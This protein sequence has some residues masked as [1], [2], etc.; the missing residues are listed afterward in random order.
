MIFGMQLAEYVKN[1]SRYVRAGIFYV[2]SESIFNRELI[3]QQNSAVTVQA[4][5]Q[6]LH[7]DLIR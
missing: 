1:A 4:A 7:F 5:D 6:E 3:T 2:G